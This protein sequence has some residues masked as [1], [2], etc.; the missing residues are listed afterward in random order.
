MQDI[1][2]LL[3]LIARAGTRRAAL[4]RELNEAGSTLELLDRSS[5]WCPDN[6]DWATARR[7]LFALA[8]FD[9]QVVP[10]WALNERFS[11]VKPLPP[12]L[13][14]RGACSLLDLPAVAIVGARRASQGALSWARL[15]GRELASRGWVIASGGALGVDGAVH[16]GGLD[17]EGLTVVYLGVA[18]DRSYPTS[19]KDLFAELLSKG[20]AIVS[21]HPPGVVTRAYDH[22]ARNRLIAAHS[23]VTIVVEAALGSGSLGTARQAVKMG[24]PVWVSPEAVAEEQAGLEWLIQE[25][26]A[27]RLEK[28]FPWGSTVVKDSVWG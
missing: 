15:C 21:E 19:H 11:C 22:A 14:V 27:E 20:G 13:F 4:A 23:S 28:R 26:L 18:I 7:Q 25:G 8:A 24:R 17:A 6:R 9:V 2:E 3:A 1:L 12:A 10:V 5:E 16:R